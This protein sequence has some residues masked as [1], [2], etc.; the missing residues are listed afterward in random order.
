MNQCIFLPKDIKNIIIEYILPPKR[1]IIKNKKE[2]TKI[3]ELPKCFNYVYIIPCSGK[4]NTTKENFFNILC[5]EL[6]I[7]SKNIRKIKQFEIDILNTKGYFQNLE[8]YYTY[9]IYIHG[10]IH[11]KIGL[12]YM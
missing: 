9:S 12:K 10:H 4:L 8:S 5:C 7:I 2:I 11:N 1:W 6:C 3:F